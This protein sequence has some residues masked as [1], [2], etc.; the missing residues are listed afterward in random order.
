MT[1][2]FSFLGLQKVEN[3]NFSFC[4][5][6]KKENLIL[7][8]EPSVLSQLDSFSKI[9]PDKINAIKNE[10]KKRLQKDKKIYLVADFEN[11]LYEVN[12]F[13]YVELIDILNALNIY[14]EDK[15]R[16]NDYGD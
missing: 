14:V 2:K 9:F 11:P 7:M 12:N 16:P 6:F 1:N 13:I 4:E 8:I 3:K 15:S 10:I 5:T